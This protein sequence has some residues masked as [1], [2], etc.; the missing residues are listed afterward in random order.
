MIHVLLA[1]SLPLTVFFAVWLFRG[2]RASLRSI[3][4]LPFAC[5]LSGAWAVIPD[6]PRLWGNKLYYTELHHRPYC[7]IW[8]FHC[9][10]DRHDQIDSSMLFPVLFVVAAV[11]VLAIGW[12]EL[13]RAEREA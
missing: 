12:R 2:R 7:D 10:I 9:T 8:W 3:L 5:L 1:S 11:A 4:I 6:S 13:R